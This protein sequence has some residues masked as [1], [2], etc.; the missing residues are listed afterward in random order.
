[1]CKD[2]KKDEVA[3]DQG[4]ILLAMINISQMIFSHRLNNNKFINI[5]SMYSLN[6]HPLLSLTHWS[7]L[8]DGF[9][10]QT[11]FR[12][13]FLKFFHTFRFC[14]ARPQYSHHHLL[15]IYVGIYV[16]TETYWCTIKSLLDHQKLEHVQMP[17]FHC[18][19]LLDLDPQLIIQISCWCPK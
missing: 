7:H 17:T 1:M 19:F 12:P 9:K 18:L 4:V 16:Q 3:Y 5:K 10:G 8:T 15:C 11:K 6:F 2:I 14:T 13:K